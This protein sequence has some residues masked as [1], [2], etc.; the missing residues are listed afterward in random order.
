MDESE[1][2]Q[3]HI[4]DLQEE[5]K[6]LTLEI[7]EEQF[8]NHCIRQKR[9]MLSASVIRYIVIIAYFLFM[10]GGFRFLENIGHTWDSLR[11]NP[12]F[13]KL[14][15]MMEGAGAVLQVVFLLVVAVA[16]VFLIRQIYFIWLN[17]EDPDA[18]QQAEKMNRLTYSRQ[19]ADSDHKLA[20][21]YFRMQEIE[22]ELEQLE[23]R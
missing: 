12:V 14:F 13:G 21:F 15:E 7:S 20:G 23:E 11:E 6:K 18:I 19:L 8:A 10:Y 2:K 5:K 16:V 22:E 17:S 3:M 1:E 9:S 4:Y